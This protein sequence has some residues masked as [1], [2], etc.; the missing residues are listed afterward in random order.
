M[1][2]QG[3]LSRQRSLRRCF[4]SS[5][6]AFVVWISLVSVLPN[7][8]IC[9]DARRPP[10]GLGL[11]SPIKV[12]HVD[13]PHTKEFS[14]KVSGEEALLLMDPSRYGVHVVKL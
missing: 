2:G 8:G 7:P 1:S 9:P 4:S 5:D 10:V 11:G 6:Y 3:R 14:Y 13:Y 12:S